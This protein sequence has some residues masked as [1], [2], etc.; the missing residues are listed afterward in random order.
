MFLLPSMSFRIDIFY[1]VPPK[2]NVVSKF[3]VFFAL[4]YLFCSGSA[5][6]SVGRV[7]D[8]GSRGHG[9]DFR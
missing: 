9:F 5:V 1:V 7:S 6:S 4:C 2:V 8:F 3:I